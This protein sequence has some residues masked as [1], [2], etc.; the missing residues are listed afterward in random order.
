MV[1]ASGTIE[2][3]AAGPVQAQ[4][5]PSLGQVS[6]HERASRPIELVVDGVDCGPAPWEGTLE[7]GPHEVFG[8][9]GALTTPRRSFVVTAGG[10]VD[11]VLAAVPRAAAPLPPPIPAPPSASRSATADE[12][13]DRGPY[14]G[15]LAQL[16]LEPGGTGSD[17][18]S[19][20]LVTGCSTG[21]PLGGGLLGYAGYQDGAIGLDALFGFQADATSINAKVQ[22]QT[23]AVTVPRLGVLGALRAHLAWHGPIGLSLA[24]GVGAAYRDIGFVGSSVESVSYFAPAVTLEG[25][26]HVRVGGAAMLSLGLMFWGENAGNGATIKA[27]PLTTPVHVARSTQAF[28]LPTLGLEFGP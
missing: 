21:A 12:T 17:A 5:P 26:V 22:T 9:S 4:P 11:I 8:R 20:P 28:V 2:T 10:A 24:A 23:L 15:V 27:P 1:V 3:V 25:A 6:I 14:G 16:L 7:A 18:C 19:A 13:S